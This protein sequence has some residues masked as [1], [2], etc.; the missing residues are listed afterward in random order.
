MTSARPILALLGTAALVAGGIGLAV[1]FN[2]GGAD[3]SLV[4]PLARAP[5]VSD[6]GAPLYVQTREVTVAEWNRCHEAGACALQLRAPPGGAADTTPATGLNWNDIQEY[7]AWINSASGHSFRLPTEAEWYAIAAPVLP[8]TPDPIFTDPELSWA[9][10][11]LLEPGADRR[12]RPTGSF[13]R[14]AEGIADLDGSVWEWTQTC[15]GGARPDRCAAFVVGG[16]HRA[17]I[18]FLVRD[19]ARGGC[20]VGV[21]PPHLGLRLVTEETPPAAIAERQIPAPPKGT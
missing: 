10:A 7:L 17:V 12:L 15:Y 20:A 8:E 1:H 4:P 16:E 5:V 21:P 2:R 19:P 13:S 11:Y 9:S 18:P 3:T 14:T 6:T